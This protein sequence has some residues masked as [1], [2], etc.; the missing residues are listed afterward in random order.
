MQESVVIAREDQLGD[1]R[2]VAYVAPNPN[3]D[4]WLSQ[5]DT[6]EAEH[7]ANWQALFEDIYGQTSAHQDLTFN[8]TGWNSSYTGLPIPAEEMGE[9][10]HHTV[11]RLLTLQP[12]RVL[13]IGCGTGLLLSRIAP[14]CS[15]ILG[16][17][18]LVE[19]LRYL[20]QVK[21]SRKELGH[22]TLTHRKA[23]D[24]EGIEA[25]EFDTVI[26]NSVVQYFPNIAYLLRVLEGAVNTVRS[27]GFIFVGDVRSLP[28]L[29]AYH[30][31]VQ[32]Y[33]AHS[34]L[35][36]V[37]LQQRI[38]QSI[39]QEEELAL[40]PAFFIAL[41]QHFP[42]ISHVQLQP[43]RGR[44]RN[45]LTRFRYDVILHVGTEGLLV[46]EPQW[47]DW[48]KETLT[49]RDIYRLLAETKPEIIG[50]RDLPECAC[51]DRN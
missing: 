50:L 23:E 49:L 32:Y 11:E 25:A 22:V 6:Q 38:Q 51:P 21:S 47:L 20:Q 5:M 3:S 19:A 24:F 41:K 28:L 30:A 40:D 1:K 29:T 12:N 31:S 37:H 17:R 8:I 18:L 33:Q 27:G 39:A 42:R 26:L 10:V 35:S 46:V 13:E 7:I 2:L 34:S 45:E 16:H 15:R 4:G 9:W 14:H 36:R 44:Y 43:K 48:R